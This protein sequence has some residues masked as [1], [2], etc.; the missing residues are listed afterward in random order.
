MIKT[1]FRKYF[2]KKKGV[3]CLL[4][5]GISQDKL[6]ATLEEMGLY[7]TILSLPDLQHTYAY[8][9]ALYATGATE[10]GNQH[11]DV[12]LQTANF[13]KYSSALIRGL[14]PFNPQIS[15]QLLEKSRHQD[16]LLRAN[17]LSVMNDRAALRAWYE[18]LKHTQFSRY[19][20]LYL[21]ANQ[22]VSHSETH[23]S[24]LNRYLSSY[25]LEPLALLHS[26]QSLQVTNICVDGEMAEYKPSSSPLVSI[27][28]TTFNSL[29]HIESA[30]LS[31]INQTYA[32]KEI[33]VVDDNSTDGTVEYVERLA[34]QYPCVKLL[35]LDRNIGTYA[36]KTIGVYV[37]KGEFVIC[38]DA[39]DWAHPRKIELQIKPLLENNQLHISFSK[40]IRLQDNGTFYARAV[41]PL[42]RLN[43]SSALF[44]KKEVMEQTG[45]WDWVR[46]GA[47]SEFN[48]RIK[49][50]FKNQYVMI[51][52]PLTIGAHRE[53]SL[54]TSAETGYS[55]VEGAA[56]RLDYWEAW[57]H[58]HI[59]TMKNK[60]LLKLN[61][62]KERNFAAPESIVVNKAD[63]L[64]CF[65]QFVPEYINR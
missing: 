4:T 49:L 13:K 65:K 30:L 53:N 42:T 8:I 54:M 26:S 18:R 17:L 11:L 36:A 9:V 28:V 23:I 31:L 15:Y 1:F 41:S 2:P 32:Q 3:E 55:S 45:L 22:L 7:Q 29:S 25:S 61:P 35:S 14:L 57:N 37:S 27:V 12:Y 64:H 63:V 19:P 34:Q 6:A 20:E 33:I 51:N 5:R 60:Q 47:D 38:H 43:P 39:D 46:T 24:N 62:L 10:K 59:Q 52:K 16:D 48:A 56:S 44:R 50:V 21:V 58:W 40:W